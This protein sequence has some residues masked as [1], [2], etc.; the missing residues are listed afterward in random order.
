MRRITMRRTIVALV[1]IVLLA[2]AGAG[3]A[4]TRRS[5]VGNYYYED[6]KTGDR[7]KIVVEVGDQVTFTVRQAAYPPHTVDVDELDIHSPDLLVGQTYTTPALK[8][9]GNF[10]L[11]CRPHEARGHH[12][13]LV[14]KAV[15]TKTTAPARTPAPVVTSGPRASPVA[16]TAGTPSPAATATPV[17]SST[18]APVGVGTAP[19]GTLARP[20][21]PDPDSLES[22]T[23]HR[24]SNQAPWT[25]ALWW[26][27]IASVPIV[28]AAA[29]ALRRNALLVAAAVQAAASAK[30]SG[31]KRKTRPKRNLGRNP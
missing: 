15:P 18:L 6:D 30:P 12:T 2:V 22:L 20:L 10:Y 16:A 3:R 5:T 9:P 29:F 27:L 24:T 21:A 25:R 23:G 28:A 13:R 4:E 17:V 19:P 8:T 7:T 1:V 26:L 31:S 11:Y 14:V